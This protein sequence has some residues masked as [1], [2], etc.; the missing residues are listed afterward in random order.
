MNDA[1][2][3]IGRNAELLESLRCEALHYVQQNPR[4]GGLLFCAVQVITDQSGDLDRH[5]G[6]GEIDPATQAPPKTAKPSHGKRAPK[7][8]GA[9][10]HKFDPDGRCNCGA[11][12]RRAPKGSG[13]VRE[14][15]EART[16]P[17]PQINSRPT[18]GDNVPD[19][20]DGGTMG[21]S[22]TRERG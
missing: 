11:A 7:G 18:I 21:S 8:Q 20:F 17:L 14:S 12:R 9:H 4:L 6:N 1:P 15:V 19:R 10:R 13:V 16:P 3:V 5:Y 22:S 2:T